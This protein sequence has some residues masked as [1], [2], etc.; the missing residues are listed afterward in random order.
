SPLRPLLPDALPSLPAGGYREFSIFRLWRNHP[1]LRYQGAIHENIPNEAI[2]EAFP[3]MKLGELSLWLWHD[4]YVQGNKNKSNRN[5]D[6]LEKELA[7]NPH[8]PYYQAM[9]ALMYREANKPGA[10]ELLRSVAD[11]ALEAEWPSTRMLAN[12]FI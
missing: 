7:Q 8:Q 2:T 6:L 1:K 10:L 4:G 5:L 3:G 12:V 11:E 9:R